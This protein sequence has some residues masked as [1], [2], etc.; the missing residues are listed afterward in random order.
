MWRC[1][2]VPE[3]ENLPPSRNFGSH[4]ALAHN[5]CSHFINLFGISKECEIPNF[6]EGAIQAVT[7]LGIE[8][9][10]FHRRINKFIHP[11]ERLNEVA[12]TRHL[13]GVLLHDRAIWNDYAFCSA[14]HIVV[15]RVWLSGDY[16]F[17][18]FA[19]PADISETDSYTPLNE[20]VPGT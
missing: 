12:A 20:S 10:D 18:K 6:T 14:T 8:A 16:I 11:S 3:V 2:T 17:T 4:S 7:D 5:F 9:G 1:I 13:K 19:D 15:N